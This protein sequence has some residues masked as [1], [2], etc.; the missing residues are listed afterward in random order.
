MSIHTLRRIR[1]PWSAATTQGCHSER[2]EESRRS[3][4]VLHSAIFNLQ[5]AIS[6]LALALCL[7]APAQADLVTGV[8]ATAS[9]ELSGRL[10]SYTTD[11]SGMSD[12]ASPTTTN[13]SIDPSPTHGETHANVGATSWVATAAADQWIQFT[14]P[15]AYTVAEFAVWNYNSDE[16]QVGG[17]NSVTVFAYDSSDSLLFQNTYAFSKGTS[18]P[19]AGQGFVLPSEVKNVK[20]ILFDINSS[21]WG[22][23]PA[24][25]EARFYTPE[26]ATLALLAFGGLG[27][28]LARK[29]K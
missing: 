25:G 2:S 8:T 3:F 28:L 15:S 22:N 6:F 1:S 5:S 29:R 18:P 10:A 16:Y 12:K 11:N 20:Y 27:M 13:F 26:P 21:W 4:R 24:L 19:T 7:A 23:K 17:L 9:S 14:F